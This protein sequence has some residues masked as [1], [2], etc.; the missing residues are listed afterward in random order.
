MMTSQEADSVWEQFSV[1][2]D[3]RLADGLA[4]ILGEILPGGVVMEKIY[5]DLFPHE[6]DQYQ[7]PVQLSGYYLEGLGPEMRE[8]I[9]SALEE[10]GQK[11]LLDQVVYS[12]L[13]NRNWATAWQERYRPIPIGDKL[14]VV[15]TWL[16]NPYPERTPVWMDPGMAFGSGT[17]PT[18][19]LC[20]SLLERSLADS[21]PEEMI[22]VGCGSGILAIAAS[23]LGVRSVLGLD[24]DPEAVRVADENARTNGVSR[25]VSFQ[26]GSVMDIVHQR[27]PAPLTVAN[28]I[29]PILLELF[30]EG[31]GELVLPGGR[32]ILSGI[33]QEQLPEIL[34][35]LELEGFVQIQQHQM[36][37]W[38]GVIAEKSPG[39]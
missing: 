33:L 8:R 9:S 10:A 26:A 28:I 1:E 32:I 29:A 16:E 22:D 13:E 24:I 25:A 20:L 21:A 5:G 14:V 12:P 27:G 38:V 19:Q 11:E 2:V 17:H 31:L 15:P 39:L 34:S 37:D 36:E 7:G 23:K 35:R 30:G 6:L 4:S 18:T 3:Q